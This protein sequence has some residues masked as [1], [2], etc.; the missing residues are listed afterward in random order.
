MSAPTRA[1]RQ[2][3]SQE[4][5]TPSAAPIAHKMVQHDIEN[6]DISAI[7]HNI[8]DLYQHLLEGA[9]VLREFSQ[10]PTIPVGVA[11]YGDLEQRLQLGMQRYG[12]PLR[13]FNGRN[14]LRDAYEEVLDALVYLKAAIFEIENPDGCPPSPEIEEIDTLKHMTETHAEPVRRAEP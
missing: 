13:A 7:Q 5:P 4:L 6:L 14:Q 2:G 1:G 9:L 11:V 12:Q 8:L 10:P 3:D